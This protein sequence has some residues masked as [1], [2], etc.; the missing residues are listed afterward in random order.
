MFSDEH[1]P[2]EIINNFHKDI[3]KCVNS[4]K[5]IKLPEEFDG[6]GKYSNYFLWKKYFINYSFEVRPSIAEVYSSQCLLLKI[7]IIKNQNIY[8]REY[9]I[10]QNYFVCHSFYKNSILFM[11]RSD[12]GNPFS[13][14]IDNLVI[15]QF[16][17]KTLKLNCYVKY[18]TI[19][20]YSYI[21][22]HDA[23]KYVKKSNC[24]DKHAKMS[25]DNYN[26]IIEKNGIPYHETYNTKYSIT[27]HSYNSTSITINKP[28]PYTIMYMCNKYIYDI[29]RDKRKLMIDVLELKR[30]LK[31]VYRF[32][33]T[34]NDD[35]PICIKYDAI[36][37]IVAMLFVD[38]FTI[39]QTIRWYNLN[40]FRCISYDIG[41]KNNIHDRYM[42]F[43]NHL[44]LYMLN[45]IYYNPYSYPNLNN[46]IRNEICDYLLN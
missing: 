22:K 42:H 35:Y 10:Q 41:H 28:Y 11:F 21:I 6:Y 26:V 3:Y 16:N 18:K 19:I 39:S 45:Y 1:I 9:V 25:N 23:S 15:V 14:E 34:T 43:D 29:Y 13:E 36:T 40:T 46:V 7:I 31:I 8:T 33:I 4:Q 2:T 44:N 37:S 27:L 32:I 30:A 38:D 17:L 12:F 24:M 5:Y 20:K